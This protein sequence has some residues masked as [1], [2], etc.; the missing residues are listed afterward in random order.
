MDGSRCAAPT[1]QL[2]LDR[3]VRSTRAALG[4]C[5]VTPV[6]VG[7]AWRTVGEDAPPL[8]ARSALLA[9]LAPLLVAGLCGVLRRQ[10][11]QRRRQSVLIGGT[12]LGGTAL[13]GVAGLSALPPLALT[14]S[15]PMLALVTIG[16]VGAGETATLLL[17]TALLAVAGGFALAV[18]TQL[19]RA[20]VLL[21]ELPG[22]N[23]RSFSR[24]GES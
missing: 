16:S 2:V 9:C 21:E 15:L 22:R 11:A 7:V 13:G 12:A 10:A 24:L 1:W 6:W 17:L 8:D 23:A 4:L 14:L 3:I 19:L 18:T 5:L 20:V